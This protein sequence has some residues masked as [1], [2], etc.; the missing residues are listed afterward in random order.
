MTVDAIRWT[1]NSVLAFAGDNDP[2][3]YIEKIARETVL[4]AMDQGYTG[5]PYEPSF[6]AR[7]MK[8]AVEADASISDARTLPNGDG[9]KI[10]Y[11]PTQSRQRVRFSVAHEVAHCLFPDVADKVRNRGG[12]QS[13][14]DDWQLEMLCN[15]AAAEFIMPVGSLPS[16]ETT[17]AIETL[18]V[19]R[20][21]YDVSAE[22]YLIRTAKTAEDA[23]MM[24]CAAPLP[25]N[26]EPEYYRVDY[27]FGSRNWPFERSND[28]RFDRTSCVSNCSAIGYTSSGVELL[29]GIGEVEVE[30]VGVSSYPG[31]A[32]PRVVGLIRTERRPSLN[33]KIK[34]V[35]GSALEPRGKSQ[36]I[37]CQVVNDRA[38]VW[39]G[40]MARHTGNA[41]PHAHDEFKS[42]M[43]D[44]PPKS[45]LGKAHISSEFD[46][47]RIASLVAQVGIG[48][49]AGPRIR[50]SALEAALESTVQ[51]AVMTKSSLHMPRI[52]TGQAG[53]SWSI[54]E[55][56][57]RSLV[58]DK[59]LNITI[60]DLPPKRNQR[61]PSLFD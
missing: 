45:A 26:S 54:I 20:N 18:M 7:M 15:I 41:F 38:R 32:Y 12:D 60:Y 23:I 46:G 16:R 40:G 43:A 56:I 33:E 3:E 49:S 58:K 1:N 44:L 28:L 9:L 11:N 39:G 21:R 57:I 35:H 36:K 52:G 2:I 24:F 51:A 8:I 5:P 30:A 22:A 42:W 34:F 10:Q 6:L 14:H 37:I 55:E 17:P 31:S 53:G 29:P 25:R 59:E 47:V 48:R 27:T 19:E 4:S 13:I 61:Q 50:Y